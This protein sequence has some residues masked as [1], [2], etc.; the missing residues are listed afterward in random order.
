[1]SWLAHRVLQNLRKGCS[2][3]PWLALDGD[4]HSQRSVTL[5]REAHVERPGFPKQRIGDIF[6]NTCLFQKGFELSKA[7]WT[8]RPFAGW[9]T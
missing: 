9:H 6:S 7:P 3:G 2:L 8:S 5:P 4:S 1:M